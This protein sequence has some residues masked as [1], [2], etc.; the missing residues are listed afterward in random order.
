MLCNP[1]N[2]LVMWF[3]CFDSRCLPV[4]CDLWV[5]Y[6]VVCLDPQF[7]ALLVALLLL[8]MHFYTLANSA[9]KK[10]NFAFQWKPCVSKFGDFCCQINWS[11]KCSYMGRD[12]SSKGNKTLSTNLLD[13][14]INVLSGG[15]KYGCS[16]KLIKRWYFLRNMFFTGQQQ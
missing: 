10:Q 11:I 14:V 13:Y 2:S 12:Y 1:C 5:E 4:A 16:A 3:T 6:V 15:L 7:P 8:R 9:P